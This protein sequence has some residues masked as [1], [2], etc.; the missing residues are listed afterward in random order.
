[1]QVDCLSIPAFLLFC[2]H[3]GIKN[4]QP[5]SRLPNEDMDV[6]YLT[7]Y[8]PANTV[9]DTCK[10]RYHIPVRHGEAIIRAQAS[11]LVYSPFAIISLMVLSVT[12]IASTPAG[13]PQ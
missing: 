9:A 13:V 4:I 12:C 5:L 1:M 11:G 8:T 3:R 10:A 6:E 7:R 2:Q